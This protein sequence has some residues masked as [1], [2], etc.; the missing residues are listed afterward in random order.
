MVTFFTQETCLVFASLEIAC[1]E[2]FEMSASVSGMR[3]SRPTCDHSLA[4][5]VLL[6]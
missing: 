3:V 5:S 4:V 1:R 2:D 6:T